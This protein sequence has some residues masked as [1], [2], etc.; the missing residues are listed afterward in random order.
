MVETPLADASINPMLLD[1]WEVVNEYTLKE[2]LYYWIAPQ[3]SGQVI[4]YTGNRVPFLTQTVFP[5][6]YCC[7]C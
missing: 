7:S 5:Y 4:C 2:I 1:L 3:G 6:S